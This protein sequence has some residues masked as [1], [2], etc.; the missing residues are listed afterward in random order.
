MEIEEIKFL[1]DNSFRGACLESALEEAKKVLRE[2][3]WVKEHLKPSNTRT[4]CRQM[5]EV[6]SKWFRV[7]S[8][9]GFRM[10]SKTLTFVVLSFENFDINVFAGC[11]FD[12]DGE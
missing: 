3:K 5:S 7:P 11:E 9:T 4:L 8:I 6:F 10:S 1:T 2:N 12:K